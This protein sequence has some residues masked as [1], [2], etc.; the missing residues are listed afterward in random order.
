MSRGPAEG[1]LLEEISAGK[2][3]SFYLISGEP[4]LAEPAALRVAQALAAAVGTEVTVHRRPLGLQEVLADLRTFSLFGGGKVALVFESA[5]LSD[6][7]AAAYLLDQAAEALPLS[8]GEELTP[9]EREAAG[10][11][12]QV[13]H[14]FEV[15]QGHSP[16]AAIS[17]LPNWVF[18][19]GKAPG[20]KSKRRKRTSKQV[21]TLREQSE[22]LLAA[23]EVAGLKGFAE[24]DA[25]DLAAV[26]QDGLPDGHCLVMAE[27]AVADDHP[28]VARVLE[29]GGF[30]RVATVQADR[31][32]QWAGTEALAAELAEETGTEIQPAALRELVKRTLRQQ[33]SWGGAAATEASST[34]RFA[35][36]YRKLSSL[37]PAGVIDRDLV[38]SVVQD[39]GQEDLWGVLDSIGVG[40]AGEAVEKLQRLID[41]ADDPM[42]ARL[43]FFSQ[44]AQFSRHLTAISGMMSLA[45]VP[46]GERNYNRFK[47]QLAPRLQKELPGTGVSLLKGL[48]PYRLHRAY[49]AVGRFEAADLRR[50]PE[51]VLETEMSLKGESLHPDAALASLVLRLAGS[52]RNA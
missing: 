34:Q 7:G 21:D 43:G 17:E 51:K 22:A 39:R 28:V 32:G 20:S 13:L 46:S 40:R 31:K 48:H 52:G 18:E 44:L 3:R 42:A 16:Q 8:G 2:L 14:L 26:Q 49:L 38:E 45:G 10:R 6:R 35:A 41:G 50:L 29:Q 36:E 4:V 25:S 1:A 5:V 23:A 12:L 27:S 24:V 30:I 33:P 47:A 37:A 15:S 11:L 19:G 9:K